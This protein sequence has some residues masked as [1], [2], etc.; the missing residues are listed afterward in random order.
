MKMQRG[1]KSPTDYGPEVVGVAVVVAAEQAVVFAPAMVARFQAQL[2]R[3][4]A[5]AS[6]VSYVKV[7]SAFWL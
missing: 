7:C 3:T 6:T 1:S 2:N 5:C 4:S